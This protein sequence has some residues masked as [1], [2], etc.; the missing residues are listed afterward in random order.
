MSAMSNIDV[1]RAPA[2]GGAAIDQPSFP[3]WYRATYPQV[4]TAVGMLAAPAAADDATAEAFA[5]AYQHWRRISTMRSPAGWTYRVAQNLV[6]RSERRAALERRL[7]RRER[8]APPSASVT[9]HLR[10]EVEEALASLPPRMRTAIV[11]RY[12][13][14]LSEE[15]VAHAMGLSIGG[16]SSLLTKARAHLRTGDQAH[17][18]RSK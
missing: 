4:R 2:P 12:V 15:D 7:L 3:D 16:A 13:A 10:L 11:L 1:T 14:D 6:R 5:R 9:T 8:P 18:R 17:D